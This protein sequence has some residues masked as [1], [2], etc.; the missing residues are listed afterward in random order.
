M[1]TNDPEE[2][3][4]IAVVTVKLL[5][6]AA[7]VPVMSTVAIF[8]PF[9]VAPVA[10]EPIVNV[11]LINIWLVSGDICVM[12]DAEIVMPDCDGSVTF[13]AYVPG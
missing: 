9:T 4:L 5:R 6:Y 1:H 8:T 3:L 12:L 13:S 10:A 2:L 7:A 11:P